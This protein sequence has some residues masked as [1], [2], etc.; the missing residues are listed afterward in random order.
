MD[1]WIFGYSTLTSIDMRNC[2]NL[3]T[4]NASIFSNCAK[5]SSIYLP[6]NLVTI[7]SGCFYNTQSLK[8]IDLPDSV[9]IIEDYLPGHNQV[10]GTNLETI[11]ISTNSKLRKIGENA[12]MD[13]KLT[14]IF[15]PKT[16]TNISASAFS[17][18]PINT[19]DV[20][21][22]N[23]I[24][25]SEGKVVYSGSGNTTLHIVSSLINTEFIVPS[26]VTEIAA[27]CFRETNIQSIQITDTII[28]IFSNAFQSTKISTFKFNDNIKIVHS[29]LFAG[30]AMI[31][32]IELSSN[33]Q[34]IQH[35]AFSGC[36]K[37]K[38]IILPETLQTIGYSAFESCSSLE[39]ISIPAAVNSIG[40]AVFKGCSS[41]LV[42]NCSLN[43][44]FLIEQGMFFNNEKR[45]LSNFF[46]DLNGSNLTIPYECQSIS[47]NV[48]A[49]SSIKSIKFSG[50]ANM[51][52]GVSSFARSKLERIELPASLSRIGNYCFQNCLRLTSVIFTGTSLSSIS[53]SC[54][55]GC[56]SLKEIILPSSITSIGANSFSGCKSVKDIGLKN[57]QVVNIYS[58]AFSKSG[59]II[60]DLPPTIKM[61]EVSA[62]TDT[63]I[64]Y[65]SCSTDVAKW[66]CQNIVTLTRV[67]L[68]N[69]VVNIGESSFENCINLLLVTIP[70]TIV[71]I[72]AS[73]FRNC[74]RLSSFVIDVNSS[75]SVIE[76]G[77]FFGCNSLTEITLDS[78]DYK[79][80]FTA[81]AL[82]NYDETQIIAFLPSS[83]ANTFVVPVKTRSIGRYA[84]MGATKLQRILF[85]GNSIESIGHQSF[86]GCYNLN[87]LYFNS[88]SIKT[89]SDTA[90]DDCPLLKRCGSISCP[91]SVKNKF[92]NFSSIS[93]QIECPSIKCQDT[94][95]CDYMPIDKLTFSIFLL[96]FSD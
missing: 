44:H 74:V 8:Y 21:S 36:I 79:L 40:S 38:N 35:D 88:D 80:R 30:N 55:S 15:I 66:C 89:I 95:Y 1:P 10:F 43:S 70:S 3:L 17:G 32:S 2:M 19:F 16:V 87:F 69:G 29:S 94:N 46:D 24:F 57:T 6:P 60:C 59:L 14:Y 61:I 27:S 49:D 47:D 58:N 4:L 77:T 22:N 62:F 78:N 12:F 23:L 67:N 75:L 5:L 26:F 82:T 41:K 39:Y 11:S 50:N 65:F 63:Q 52:F 53:T 64:T 9:Q 51:V 72:K 93:F 13:S 56:Q 90:F 85:N 45:V 73:A 76:G 20:D 83:N 31:E 54:F 81:G 71:S 33:T 7:S 37:L 96:V 18:V 91:D 86:K 48:F 34:E 28:N 25:K 68:T 42:V 84:F 92:K